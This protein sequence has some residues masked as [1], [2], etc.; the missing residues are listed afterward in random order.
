MTINVPNEGS[1]ELRS[2]RKDHFQLLGHHQSTSAEAFKPIERW[3]ETLLGA[4]PPNAIAVHV[5][6]FK[7]VLLLATHLPKLPTWIHEWK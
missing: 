5:G 3:E 6:H 2:Q 4:P 7:D 1:D